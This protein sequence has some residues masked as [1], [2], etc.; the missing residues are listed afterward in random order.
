[1]PDL[2][3]YQHEGAE[4]L[5]AR[6]EAMLVFGMGLGKTATAITAAK[7]LNPKRI[8]VVCPAVARVNWLREM[9]MWWPERAATV[10][11]TG[12][13]KP[14]EDGVTIVS[15]DLASR[16]PTLTRLRRNTGILILDEVQY[17]KSPD[18]KRTK[19]LLTDK[20]A[21][22]VF[23]ERV[24][25]LSGTPA[26]NHPA[27]LWPF[28]WGSGIVQERYWTF[29]DK[30]CWLVDEGF[31]RQIR[32]AKRP[33]MDDLRK[34][35]DPYWLRKRTEDVLPDLPAIR[36]TTTPVV[37]ESMDAVTR[38]VIRLRESDAAPFLEA[39][40]EGTS[41]PNSAAAEAHLTT[42]QRLLELAKAPA[43]VALLEEEL[44]DGAMEKVVIFC[45]F[46]A[47]IDLLTERFSEFNPAVVYGGRTEKQRQDDI[48]RFVNDPACRVFIGQ[49]VAAG[50]AITL[51]AGGACRDA[52]FLSA[53]FVPANNAQAAKRIHRIGQ[54][55]SVLVRF[56]FAEG[57]IDEA[58]M[59]T[60]ARKT[61]DLAALYQEE[62]QHHVVG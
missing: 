31:G 26:P 57:S 60:L 46:R 20:A 5:A 24:W 9:R 36:I 15:Y 19:A 8:T 59:S 25:A 27:E 50:T 34:R 22:A 54:P 2:Y 33:A 13:D 44:R 49:I 42:L 21:L 53:D 47:T 39:L 51:H 62:V 3:P 30:Y 61:A 43:A 4:F 58:V 17:C 14:L 56:L 12:Q 23:A 32:G 41:S 28:L 16:T 1:M 55:N 10:V 6:T 11:M 48:D 45:R 52:V 38:E 7:R 40:E 29:A 18:A 37:G 35:L